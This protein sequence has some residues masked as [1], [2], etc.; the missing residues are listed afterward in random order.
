MQSLSALAWG[1]SNTLKLSQRA[2]LHPQPR[3]AFGVA[4]AAAA[5]SECQSHPERSGRS[6]TEKLRFWDFVV[7]LFSLTVA[8]YRGLQHVL[9]AYRCARSQPARFCAYSCGSDVRGAAPCPS[10]RA[11]VYTAIQRCD[12]SMC[13]YTPAS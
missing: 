12:G 9:C 4:T 7:K 5:C 8:F 3:T 1:L 11:N 10:P 13:R 2:R 6:S